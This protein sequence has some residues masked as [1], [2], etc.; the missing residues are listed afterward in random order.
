MS[1]LFDEY[2][3]FHGTLPA[4]CVADC[5]TQ[6]SVDEAVTYWRKQLNFEV[7]RELAIRWLHEYGAWPLESDEYDT[8]LNQ[9]SDEDIAEKVLWLACC[10]L[11]ENGEWFGLVH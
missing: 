1:T 7:P 4:D 5:S 6:G 2:G 3:W 8:G 11:R 10:D 9:M